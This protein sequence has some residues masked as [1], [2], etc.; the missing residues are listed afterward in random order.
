MHQGE[1]TALWFWPVQ[2]GA[3]RRVGDVMAKEAVWSPKGDMIAFVRGETI[4]TTDTQGSEA[5]EV[6]RFKLAPHSLLW[7]PDGKRLRFTQSNLVEGTDSMWEIGLDGKSL[8]RVLP[9]E[10]GGP[11]EGSGTWL[12]GGD[13]FAFSRGQGL[14]ANPA[15]VTQTILGH[16]DGNQG[17][18]GFTAGE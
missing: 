18:F 7:S 5:R 1:E 3:P 14:R 16:M 11:H 15:G 17:A 4:L 6:A 9:G 13:F 10:E 12:A 2:G 8:R